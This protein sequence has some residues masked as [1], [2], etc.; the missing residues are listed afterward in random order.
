M[1]TAD[2]LF[3]NVATC[4]RT[5]VSYECTEFLIRI[6]RKIFGEIEEENVIE[7]DLHVTG[8]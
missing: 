1:R 3:E 2:R 8:H 6:L 7:C 5:G 4:L